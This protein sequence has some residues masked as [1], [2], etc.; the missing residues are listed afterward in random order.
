MKLYYYNSLDIE[1][2]INVMFA[3]TINVTNNTLG[4]GF[5]YPFVAYTDSKKLIK[6]LCEIFYI[7]EINFNTS[8]LDEAQD[9]FYLETTKDYKFEVKGHNRSKKLL[10]FAQVKQQFLK[11]FEPIVRRQLRLA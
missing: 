3:K 2:K 8:D 7:S 1:G 10:D 11:E 9:T 4:V 6:K 5:D